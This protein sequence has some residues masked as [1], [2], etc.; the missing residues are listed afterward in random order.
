M[1]TDTGTAVAAGTYA[2]DPGASRVRFTATHSFGLK[3]VNG[4]MTVRDGTITLSPEAGRCAVDARIDAASFTTDS[5]KRDRDVTSRRFL[6]AANHPDLMFVSDRLVRDG[7][8]WLL[9]GS[10]TV[11]G[12]TAPVELEV[13][14]GGADVGGCRFRACARVDRYAHRVG[15]RGVIARHLD[16]ELDI[17]GVPAA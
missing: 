15:P 13:T 2:I 9:H 14:S 4:T 7:D 8:R 16:V 12:V 6:D 3:P 17:L 1:T 11:K 5:P 10:L